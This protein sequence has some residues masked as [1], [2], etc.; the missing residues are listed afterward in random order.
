LVFHALLVVTASAA[1]AA[2]PITEQ[3]LALL[4]QTAPS[5]PETLRATKNAKQ[6]LHRAQEA[7][8]A[9]DEQVRATA[10][11]LEQT[12]LEWAK[13]RT[14]L[15]DLE[16]LQTANVEAQVRLQ[17]LEAQLKRE[18]AYLEETEARRGRALAE[19]QKLGVATTPVPT[20][21]APTPAPDRKEAQ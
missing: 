11:V 7:A 5:T 12:A 15:T 18:Q 19:L 16:A 21:S 17:E 1:S 2:P 4:E 13:L 6:T 10:E 9:E 20:T 8:T 14:E 3:V